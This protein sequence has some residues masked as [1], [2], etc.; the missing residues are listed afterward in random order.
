M[1]FRYCDE[2]AF[3]FSW[4]AE[5]TMTRTSHCLAGGGRVWFVDPVDWPEAIERAR[6]VGD[7]AAVL[8]LLDRHNRDCASVAARLGVPHSLRRQRC[9]IRRSRSSR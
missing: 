2:T 1:A 8:Q 4:V 3:G 6:S 7:P 5:E 9:P